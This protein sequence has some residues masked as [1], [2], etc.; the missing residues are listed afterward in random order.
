MPSSETR[1][2]TISLRI[3]P[4]MA[5]ARLVPRSAVDM[6]I[7]LAAQSN[8]GYRLP[9]RIVKRRESPYDVLTVL[10]VEHCG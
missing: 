5:A 6:T 8:R 3:S 9:G 2:L 4:P 1:L 7:R 10:A